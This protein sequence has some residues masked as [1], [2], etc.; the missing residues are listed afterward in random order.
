MGRSRC[1][2]APVLVVD[3]EHHRHRVDAL[4]T[5]EPLEIRLGGPG[6]Q[7]T[8]VV[9]TMRTPGHDF[10]LAAGF[11]SSE[12]LVVPSDI[13]TIRYCVDPEDGTQQYNIVTVELRR[14]VDPGRLTRRFGATAACGLCGKA[15]LDDLALRCGPVAAGFSVPA[16]LFALLPERL[17]SQ[18][19]IFDQTGGLHAAALFEKNGDLV[20]TREDVGR[21]NAVDKVIG[22]VLLGHEAVL[23]DHI[24]V[25][26]GRLGFEIVQKA[27]VAGIPI[28]AAVSAPSTLAVDTA[29]RFGITLVAFL[30]GDHFNVYSHPER[31]ALSA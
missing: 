14:P 8:S 22:A 20:V 18:Q 23:A 11:L 2:S 26:S 21:H 9:V 4:A 31:V 12:E 29:Q 7:P 28:V 19:R 17:R 10:E 24:L 3:G 6:Q 27:A 30:R 13:R 25:V 15:T 5:E 16:S 1:A